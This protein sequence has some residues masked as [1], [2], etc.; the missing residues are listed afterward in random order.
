MYEPLGLPTSWRSDVLI[1]LADYHNGA[2]FNSK[3]WARDGLPII[4]IEQINNPDAETD[5]YSGRVLPSNFIDTGDLIF[6][7]SATLKVVK[8]NAGP[9][10]LNQHLYK[11]VLMP[12]NTYQHLDMYQLHN[13]R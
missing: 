1:N 4:R 11:V 13:I 7:W 5:K 3:H 6:S 2:A 10:V 12:Y 9:A 8:W